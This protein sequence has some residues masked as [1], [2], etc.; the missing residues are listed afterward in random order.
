MGDSLRV[1]DDVTLQLCQRTFNQRNDYFSLSRHAIIPVLS[2]ADVL[3][4][5]HVHIN[6]VNEEK[7]GIWLSTCSADAR[8]RWASGV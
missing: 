1:A 2:L 3:E 7:W 4:K 8:K 5:L 6:V